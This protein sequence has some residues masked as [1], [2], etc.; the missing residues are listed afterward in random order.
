MDKQLLFLIKNIIILLI[1]R[2]KIELVTEKN[3]LI[4][5]FHSY[6]FKYFSFA[7]SRKIKLK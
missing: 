2:T 6:T 7:D 4:Y 1:K 3:N 5:F